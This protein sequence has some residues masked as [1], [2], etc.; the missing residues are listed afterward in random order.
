MKE[1]EEKKAREEALRKAQ[2]EKDEREAIVLQER[3]KQQREMELGRA[4]PQ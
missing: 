2:E 3:L 4:V 1:K